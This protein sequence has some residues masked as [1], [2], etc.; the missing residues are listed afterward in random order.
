MTLLLA[1]TAAY[2]VA[3]AQFQPVPA[4]PLVA[5]YLG[6]WLLAA[7]FIACGLCVSALTESQLVASAAKSHHGVRTGDAVQIADPPAPVDQ[8]EVRLG[9][10]AR[11]LPVRSGSACS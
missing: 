11:Q 3:L 2:P 4:G 6:L 10:S 9:V 1:A 8:V 7:G 5:G